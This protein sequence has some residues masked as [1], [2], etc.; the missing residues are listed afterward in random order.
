MWFT[1]LD[2]R[3]RNGGDNHPSVFGWSDATGSVKRQKKNLHLFV[4]LGRVR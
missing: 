3:E 1:V 4:C 2:W